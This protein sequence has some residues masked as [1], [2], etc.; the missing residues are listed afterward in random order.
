MDIIVK[1]FTK[2]YGSQKAVD[3]ISF[4]VKTGEILGFLGPNGAGKTTTM[5]AITSYLSPSSGTISV[6]E[7]STT[8]QPEEVK[9]I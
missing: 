3:D 8:D 6:G 5:K 2:K 9:S 4:E 1:H 7:Y